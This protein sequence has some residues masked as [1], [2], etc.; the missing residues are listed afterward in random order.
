MTEEI[1]AVPAML[2]DPLWPKATFKTP[3]PV[4][5]F[6]PCMVKLLPLLT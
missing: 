5:P 1:K 4:D 3:E 2:N 6:G